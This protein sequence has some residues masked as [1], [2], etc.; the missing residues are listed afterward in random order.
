[1]AKRER[2]S[3]FR[4][5][6]RELRLARHSVSAAAAFG[7]GM[8]ERHQSWASSGVVS[9]PR[10]THSTER[11]CSRAPIRRG[12]LIDVSLTGPNASPES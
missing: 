3:G 1:M 10:E 4:R 9:S 2:E 5:V 12:R 8:P 6:A 11:F 7:L